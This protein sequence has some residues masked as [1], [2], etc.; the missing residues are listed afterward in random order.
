MAREKGVVVDNNFSA[1]VITEAS[2]LNF[3]PN[4]C[5]DAENCVFDNTGPVYRRPPIDFENNYTTHTASRADSVVTSYVWKSVSGNA[6]LTLYVKQIGATLYFYRGIAGAISPGLLA[7]TINLATYVPSAGPS[8]ALNECEFSSGLGYLFVTH[9]TL[10]PFYVSFNETT[11]ALTATQITVQLRDHFGLTEAVAVDNRPNTLTDTHN[12]N[13][14]N[15]GWFTTSRITAFE[16]AVTDYPSNADVWWLYKDTDDQFDV[17]M[18]S[19]IEP[20]TTQAS[21]GHYVLNAFNQDRATA[22]GIGGISTVT[23]SYFRPNVSAFFAGR[24]FYGGVS[25]PG[26][27]GRILF[28]QIVVDTAQ[29]G[30]CYQEADPTSQ[31]NFD[32]TAS[33]GG[34]FSIP[35]CGSIHNLIAVN[36]FLVVFATNGVWAISGSG[37]E[38]GFTANSYKVQQIG[39]VGSISSKSFVD[40]RGLPMFWSLEG[41]YA[42]SFTQQGGLEVQNI[43]NLKIRSLYLD[44]PLQSRLYARGYF[45]PAEEEIQW[46]YKSEEGGSLTEIYEFDRILCFNT[47]T[48]AFSPW[49]FE[50]SGVKIHD[51]FLTSAARSVASSAIVT[52]NAAANVTDD[53]LANVTVLQTIS[54]FDESS[55]KYVVSYSDSGTKFTIAEANSSRET[56]KDWGAVVATDYDS[57]F[58]TGYRLRTQGAR[59]FQSHYLFIFSD[60]S[61]EDSTCTVKA[62]WDFSTSS[63]TARWSSPQTVSASTGDY[64]IV[65]RKR[66]IRGQGV[67]VQFKFES[68]SGSGF[69]IQG[70]SVYDTANTDI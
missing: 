42:V 36:N 47:K 17:T 24:L 52:N 43:S 60:V 28:S 30:K 50:S 5:S 67:V 27:E 1:G 55:F 46:L 34:Y 21:K 64:T 49:V 45:N 37:I 62:L 18:V 54:S 3:P 9:P 58:V 2:G 44:I 23:T 53:A 39:L 14:R 61:E 48:G 38:E 6:A 40:V 59:P 32:L 66:L 12:Y 16:A 20:G 63:G 25:Y 13:L 69:N 57:Y 35:N 11:E 29:L 68:T 65:R 56:Y 31:Q 8:A 15:Q 4:S 51:I 22:S 7:G 70:W 19:H 33:D 10:E 41:I 26:W